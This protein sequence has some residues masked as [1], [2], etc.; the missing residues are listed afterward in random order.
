MGQTF[1]KDYFDTNPVN[2]NCPTCMSTG[3]IP[4]VGG[5]FSH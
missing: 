2:Y 1:T 5:R 4:N 3:K